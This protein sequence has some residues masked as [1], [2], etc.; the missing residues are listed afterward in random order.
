MMPSNFERKARRKQQTRLTFD[1]SSSPANMSPAKVRY[2]LPGKKQ[3]PTPVSSFIGAIDSESEDVLSSTIRND[4]S[5]PN[6]VVANENQKLPFKPLPTPAKSSQQPAKVD[7]SF[8]E[9]DASE[10]EPKTYARQTRSSFIRSVDSG[11]KKH[12]RHAMGLDG[13]Y[14]SS[15]GSEPEDNAYT[16]S[17]KKVKRALVKKTP[18]KTKAIVIDSDRED[19]TAVSL[20]TRSNRSSTKKQSYITLSDSSE[21]EIVQ[22]NTRSSQRRQSSFR[23]SKPLQSS[24][25]V[26]SSSRLRGQKATVRNESDSEDHQRSS[27]PKRLARLTIPDDEDEDEEDVVLVSPRRR[28]Q[29]PVVET[30]DDED[31]ILPLSPRKRNPR[32]TVETDEDKSQPVRSPLK[33]TRQPVESDSDVVL[34]PTKRPRNSEREIELSSDS[35]LP[36]PRTMAANLKRKS[37]SKTPPRFTRQ[38]KTIRRHRTEKEKTMELMKRRRAGENIEEVTESSE[39]ESA[40]EDEDDELQ[41]LSEFDDEEPSPEVPR[42]PAKSAKRKSRV[43][44]SDGELDTDDFVTEDEDGPIGIPDM[45]LIPLEFT[46]AAHKPIKEHFKDVV[47]WMVHNKVNPGFEWKDPVYETAFRK[48]DAECGG[49]ADSKF[50]STQWTAAFTRAVY[51]R[52][53]LELRKLSPGEGIDVLGEAKCEACNHRKHVPTWSIQ[54]KGKAYNKVTLEEIDQDSSDDDSDDN[55]SDSSNDSDKASVDEKGQRLLSQDKTWFAGAVCKQNAEQAHT[56]I[57]WK[58]HLNDWV[59]SRL[60]EEGE[61]TPAKLA[62][63]DKMKAKQRH[64]YANKI[65]DRWQTQDIIKI[66]Y[67]DFKTQKDTARELKEQKRGGW[68]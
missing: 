37:V 7:T 64:K 19:E 40:E 8:D 1:R 29:Q 9:L 39:S 62:E 21:D 54:F 47:E 22:S 4:F 43:Q 59:I 32:A 44:N 57:H 28:R 15:D 46:S 53:I 48:V 42:Q 66:L 26:T 63:R 2:E 52:P 12:R 17:K 45:S 61:C 6:S 33:R 31:E 58:W 3:R 5:D 50:V 27:P 23:K 49:F 51:A 16:P 36:S 25:T 14:S 41:Q 34:S 35:D 13:T 30:E 55:A 20:P 18:S 24:P 67:K 65:V 10:D 56:L 11:K 38:Q 68:K 60:E